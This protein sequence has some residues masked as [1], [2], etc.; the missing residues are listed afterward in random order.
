MSHT[1]NLCNSGNSKKPRNIT[2]FLARSIIVRNR[3]RDIELNTLKQTIIFLKNKDLEFCH[4]STCVNIIK[5]DDSVETYCSFCY[6]RYCENHLQLDTRYHYY[7][8]DCLKEFK[9]K[10]PKYYCS[11]LNCYG[12]P[13]GL[14][15][16]CKNVLYSCHHGHS[17]NNSSLCTVCDKPNDL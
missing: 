11:V 13:W 10:E 16:N 8:I 5:T 7:C 12:Q 17:S 14:C 4:E 1:K 9:L 2:E 3:E 6:K 15:R